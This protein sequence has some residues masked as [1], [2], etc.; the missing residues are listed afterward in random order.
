MTVI[1]FLYTG[2]LS[3]NVLYIQ[4]IG[5]GIG[6]YNGL[7]T[8]SITTLVFDI[9]I[10]LFAALCISSFPVM[11]YQ[12]EII[13]ESKEEEKNKDKKDK[14]EDLNYTA[15][16]YLVPEHFLILMFSTIGSCLLICASDLFSIYLAIELQSFGVYI[17]ASIFRKK[18]QVVVAGLKYFLLGSLSSCII[19]LGIGLVYSYSGFTS[20]ESIYS[21]IV[22]NGN[23]FDFITNFNLETLQ[24]ILSIT[25]VKK[26]IFLS[27]NAVELGLLLIIIGFLFKIGAAPLHN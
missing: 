24:D 1:A 13:D 11:Y 14:D 20:L 21:F 25:A 17:I 10:C 4:F 12:P 15:I 7:F 16:N 27:K 22:F 23:F 26:Q 18:T 8:C 9:V 5:S 19:L 3:Y 2:A 6:I